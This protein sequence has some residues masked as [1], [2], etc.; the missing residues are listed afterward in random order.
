MDIRELLGLENQPKP[1]H[2]KHSPYK[3]FHKW[4]Y[5]EEVFNDLRWVDNKKTINEQ[6]NEVLEHKAALSANTSLAVIAY[7]FAVYMLF[8]IL[9][10]VRKWLYKK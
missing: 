9:N 6:R 5:D 7:I 1:T 4:K 8:Y 10:S 3:Y 2:L